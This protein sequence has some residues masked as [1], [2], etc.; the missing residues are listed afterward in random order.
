M[1]S[2]RSGTTLRALAFLW[3]GLL[4]GF[5]L[6]IEWFKGR[7]GPPPPPSGGIDLVGAGATF[8]YPLY[9]RWFSDY[10]AESGVRINY[11]SVGSGEGIRLMLDGEVDFG[12]TDRPLR[13]DERARATCGPL[14]IP[15]VIGAVAVVYNL[16]ELTEPLRLDA[17]A[18]S[19]IFLGHVTRWDAPALRALNPGLQLPARPI[20][21]VH[22][23]G[24]SGTS[25]IFRAYLAGSAIGS[26]AP[27]TAGPPP[28]AEG[29]WPVGTTAEGNEGV[30]TQVRVTE[31]AIGFVEFAYAEQAQLQ[32]AALR[33]VS[34]VFVTP[35]A[36]SIAVAAGELLTPAAADTASALLGARARSAYALPA[37]T[38]IVADSALG[39]ATRAAHLIAFVR[40]ALTDGARAAAELG[41]E[42][43]PGFVRDRIAR[44]LDALRPGTCP[45]G[46]GR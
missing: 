9:R 2:F 37:V 29:R 15:M 23:A 4:A 46:S 26:P 11:F 25:D 28:G 32:V 22:R 40:W 8:P 6:G 31:G 27:A 45:A 13:A 7:P 35:R 34:G 14:D 1:P 42:P 19:G 43:L 18:L 21:V 16:P 30:A 3:I 41:Y 33:N 12:A 38:R 5:A 10:R 39:D 24:R 20:S 44:R 17:D 36:A